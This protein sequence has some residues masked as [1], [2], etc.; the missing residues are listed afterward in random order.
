MIL[1][2]QRFRNFSSLCQPCLWLS[3]RCPGPRRARTLH[4]ALLRFWLFY[5]H[6]NPGMRMVIV[7]TARVTI[8]GCMRIWGFAPVLMMILVMTTFHSC[9]GDHLII[10]GWMR[11]LFMTTFDRWPGQ[12]A[13]NGFQLRWKSLQNPQCP[14]GSHR[15]SHTWQ[16]EK[17][18]LMG[19]VDSS[20]Q[21]G[22]N[23]VPSFLDQNYF[24]D[25]S[26]L[27]C[28]Q[29]DSVFSCQISN[30]SPSLFTFDKRYLSTFFIS[31]HNLSSSW[32]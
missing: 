4:C 12:G 22:I 31:V 6:Q 21:G 13:Q 26:T 10:W 20:Y 3:N 29:H 27:T 1:I 5:I 2:C 15:I 25:F 17:S 19:G 23:W 16:Q 30:S 8:W 24:G 7:S 9:H 32:L 28:L 14:K 11:I 18:P